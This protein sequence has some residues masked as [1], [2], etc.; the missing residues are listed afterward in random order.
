MTVLFPLPH[1]SNITCVLCVRC[2]G[3]S[4][5]ELRSIKCCGEV[6]GN[7]LGTLEPMRWHRWVNLILSLRAA[8]VCAS[9]V[10]YRVPNFSCRRC[11]ASASYRLYCAMDTGTNSFA[12]SS[13]AMVSI[14]CQQQKLVQKLGNLVPKHGRGALVH[15]LVTDCLEHYWTQHDAI[16]L[17]RG[18]SNVKQDNHTCRGE[19]GTPSGSQWGQRWAGDMF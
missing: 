4:D 14:A 17:K 6:M 1:A 13:A 12:F 10:Q 2:L 9:A 3:I 5:L 8:T 18:D 15:C 11:A 16:N 7:I 19:F